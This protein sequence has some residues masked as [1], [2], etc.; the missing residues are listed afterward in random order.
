MSLLPSL[1]RSLPV[2]TALAAAAL[3][4]GSPAP[5]LLPVA[6]VPDAARAWDA[7]ERAASPMIARSAFVR[8]DTALLAG[9]PVVGAPPLA[10]LR[11]DLFAESVL[12]D[13]ESADW[14]LGY[15]VFTG[16]VR[17][18]GGHAHLAVAPDGVTSGL[19]HFGDE[20]F[21]IAYAA[22]SDIHVLQAIDQ[23]RLPAHLGCG[24][25]HS[26]AVAAPAV[27]LPEGGT[28]SDCGKT[29]LDLLV[30]YTP[31]ARQN[32]GGTSAMQAAV[33]AAVDQANAGNV[34]SGVPAEFRLVHM[35]ET[36]YAELGSGTDLSRFRGTTDGYMDEVH[37]LRA[38]YGG[39]LMQ[40]ITNPANPSYCGIAYL[41]SNL[42]TGFKHSAFGVTVRTCIPGHTFTHEIGHNIGC[43]HDPA[44]A[45]NAIY[46]Y[47]YGY[48]TP[49]NAYRSIMSYSPGT[50]VNRWSGP[51]V[52]YLGYTMGVANSQDNARSIGDTRMTVSQFFPTQAPVWCDL[53]GGIP[54]QLGLPTLTGSGT[55]NLAAPLEVTVRDY[56]P[57]VPGVLVIGLSAGN[58]PLFGGT[59]VPTPD[60][61]VTL[62][63]NG[64][65]IVY[66]ASWLASFPPG[67]QAW[68][69]VA[70]LDAAA[71]QGISASD[72]VRVSVP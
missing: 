5:V 70:F 42:S 46:P 58:V 51:N 16:S 45:G 19:I 4:Q 37:T 7:R 18:R 3:A 57:N 56:R 23:S 41:M 35:A 34:A 33:V 44:N 8:V 71:A 6:A 62:S 55:I 59:L 10:T 63:G 13:V 25:D 15:R 1:P 21:A 9:V 30:F 49:D 54:G 38:T 11:L 66:D 17:G 36:N 50:R 39:D 26:H 31:L 60:V 28:N 47:S 53:S 40:L 61:A 69:Q 24:V 52:Q 2:L 29:I 67:V 27:P 12:L 65:A 68:F 14:T 43:H 72:G 48:R 20:S 32:A 64:S 22:H